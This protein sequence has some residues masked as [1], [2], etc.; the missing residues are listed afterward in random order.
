MFLEALPHGDTTHRA[1]RQAH[2]EGSQTIATARKPKRKRKR[3]VAA[4]QPHARSTNSTN[5]ARDSMPSAQHAPCPASPPR[6]TLWRTAWGSKKSSRHARS[7]LNT[8]T[9]AHKRP[10]DIEPTHVR[11]RAA[12]H[13]STAALLYPYVS[14]KAHPGGSRNQSAER[15]IRGGNADRRRGPRASSSPAGCRPGMQ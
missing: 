15:A 7:S 13:S 4:C 12:H 3:A 1:E 5:F 11:H 14:I 8:S 9:C 10:P 2:E 6:Q